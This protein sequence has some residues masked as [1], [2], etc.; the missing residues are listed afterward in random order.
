MS[1]QSYKAT[2][3]V[4]PKYAALS[5]G[6]VGALDVAWNAGFERFT[7]RGAE[8][9]LTRGS[10]DPLRRDVSLFLPDVNTPLPEVFRGELPVNFVIVRCEVPEKLLA[11]PGWYVGDN[12]GFPG[13]ACDIDPAGRHNAGEPMIYA[14]GS[15]FDSVV[16]LFKK[17]MTG[18]LEPGDD[19]GTIVRR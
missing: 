7:Y 11:K 6:F 15:N 5:P 10:G 16:G 4:Y 2:V 14:N 3:Q 13:A 8:F 19:Q 18:E 12:Y 1:D 17:V 9:T